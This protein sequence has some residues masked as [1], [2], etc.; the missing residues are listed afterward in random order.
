MKRK[1]LHSWMILITGTVVFAAIE[2]LGYWLA[3]NGHEATLLVIL[4]WVLWL[5]AFLANEARARR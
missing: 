3:A 4:G 2:G 1:A 5:G